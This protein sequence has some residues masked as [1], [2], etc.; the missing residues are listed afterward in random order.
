MAC[1]PGETTLSIDHSRRLSGATTVD[2]TFT[3]KSKSL[4]K[5]VG[6]G[7]LLEVPIKLT[8]AGEHISENVGGSAG[9][10]GYRDT[11]NVSSCSLMS[12]GGAPNAMPEQSGIS[13]ILFPGPPLDPSRTFEVNAFLSDATST[14]A[15]C[16]TRYIYEFVP[17][18]Q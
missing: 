18:N 8:V 12:C 14:S 1:T 4:P 7:E 10:L 3:F 9:F 5:V 2:V 6:V 15:N 13:R 11:L 17:A 16:R